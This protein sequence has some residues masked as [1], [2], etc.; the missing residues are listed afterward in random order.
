MENLFI[1]HRN[2]WN[3]TTTHFVTDLA[4]IGQVAVKNVCSI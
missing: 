3:N 1:M 4:C 2:Y